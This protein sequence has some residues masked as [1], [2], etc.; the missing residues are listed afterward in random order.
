VKGAN[1]YDLGWWHL[2]LVDQRRAWWSGGEYLNRGG[3]VLVN[4]DRLEA[5]REEIGA[6][7]FDEVVGLFLQ[8]SAEVVERLG[9]QR[10]GDLSAEDLH[11]LK[12]SALTLGFDDLADLCRRA[13]MGDQAHPSVLRELWQQSCMA[14]KAA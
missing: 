2:P 4:K 5:L 9:A 7:G 6:D 8:E 3:E 11:F 14:Y 10:P 13:E 1:S 12:G